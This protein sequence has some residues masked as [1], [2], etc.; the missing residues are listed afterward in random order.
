MG[1]LMV[2]HINIRQRSNIRSPEPAPRKFVKIKF[3]KEQE[4]KTLK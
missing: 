3:E 4:R 2:E 1:M